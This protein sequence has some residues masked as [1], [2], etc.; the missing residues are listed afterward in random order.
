MTIRC[1]ETN[2]RDRVVDMLLVEDDSVDALVIK[3]ELGKLHVV[4]TIH[5]VSDGVEALDFL[6]GDARQIHVPLVVILDLNLPRMNGIE[7]L[8]RIRTDA[9]L[10]HLIVFVWTTSTVA[11]DRAKAYDRNVAGYIIKSDDVEEMQ[12]FTAMIES[13]V[14]VIEFP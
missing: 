2:K 7:F 6:R 10:R 3:R 5:V 1:N 12:K 14:H 4:R 13:Y 8:E 9:E 11:S